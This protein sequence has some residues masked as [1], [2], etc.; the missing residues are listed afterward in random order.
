MEPSQGTR[1]MAEVLGLH[2]NKY[3]FIDRDHQSLDTVA[4]SVPGI[5]VCGAA[6]GPADLDDTISSAGAAAAKAVALLRRV[7]VPI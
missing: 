2:S 7:E 4:S 6:T 3:G 5:F 1:R